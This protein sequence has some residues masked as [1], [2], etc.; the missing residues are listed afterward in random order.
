MLSSRHGLFRFGS[1][2]T[3][4]LF[5]LHSYRFRW[6]ECWKRAKVSFDDLFAY[7]FDECLERDLQ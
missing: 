6:E 1:N 2:T 5:I 3:Q 7:I 4:I